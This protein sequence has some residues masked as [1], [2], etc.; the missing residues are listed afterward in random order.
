MENK[1]GRPTIY[2]EELLEK[3]REYL[4][5]SE[6]EEE[7]QMIGLSAKGTELFKNKLRVNLPSIEGLSRFLG[8]SRETIYAW[9][10]EKEEF[11]D[12]INNLRA[13]QAE[14]LINKGLSGDYNSTIAKVLLTKH[15]YTDK[16][17]SDVTSKGES[18]NPIL[19]RFID[20]NEQ[21]N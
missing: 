3:A 14:A 5:A 8:V 10:K 7:Q 13:K 15:G 9:E 16:I 2:N 11:S 21:H 1:G 18:I 17:E 19:V 20:G 4:N 6:D 12:I